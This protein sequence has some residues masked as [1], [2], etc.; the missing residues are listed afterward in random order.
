MDDIPTPTPRELDILKVLW[1]RGAS[2][3]RTVHQHLVQ[4]EPELAY[5][6]IQTMLRIMESKR[7][8]GH[9]LRGR[10]FIYSAHFTRD[11]SMARFLDGVFDGAA[12]Q[13]VQSMLLTEKISSA[14]LEHI[15]ALIDEA[16]RRK[17]A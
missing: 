4:Q 5:N 11:D 10:T 15:Q 7:L 6:T 3:V 17:K 8:V 12:S 16:R 13:M 14:E 2:S 1:D 9:G